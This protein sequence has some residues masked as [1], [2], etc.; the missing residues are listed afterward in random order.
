[1][2]YEEQVHWKAVSLA[3]KKAVQAQGGKRDQVVL[4]AIRK[5]VP[6]L[7]VGQEAPKVPP[8]AAPTVPKVQASDERG[9]PDEPER[10]WCTG[11]FRVRACLFFT[12]F[13]A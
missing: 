5:H 9:D 2:S 10:E 8:Q 4:P 12:C 6:G 7:D 13:L 11:L 3:E 1:M